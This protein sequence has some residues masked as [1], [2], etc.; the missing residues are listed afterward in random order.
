MECCFL[1]FLR[2]SWKISKES[3]C[4]DNLETWEK[5]RKQG[6]TEGKWSRKNAMIWVSNS[7]TVKEEERLEFV[8]NQIK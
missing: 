1:A 5:Q 7:G 4:A 3:D 6:K 8:E 2:F